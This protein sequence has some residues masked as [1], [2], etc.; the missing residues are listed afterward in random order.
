MKSIGDMVK[1]FMHGQRQEGQDGAVGYGD[2]TRNVNDPW[3]GAQPYGMARSDIPAQPAYAQPQSTDGSGQPNP[4]APQPPSGR[5]G[6][7]VPPQEYQ[8]YGGQQ[9]YPTQGYPTQ[10]QGGGFMGGGL[11][12]GVAGGLAG[13]MIGNALFGPHG[14]EA[15]PAHGEQGQADASAGAPPVGVPTDNASLAYEPAMVGYDQPAWGN[16]AGWGDSD[17]GGG[18]EW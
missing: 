4:Y 12:T 14:A 3:Q 1:R 15:A 16:D 11:V 5:D 6:Y 18:G 13:S 8:P 17:S 9:G 7:P 10:G 2:Q